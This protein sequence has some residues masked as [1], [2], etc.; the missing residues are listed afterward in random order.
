M[1]DS[2]K[3]NGW[4]AEFSPLLGKITTLLQ[5]DIILFY[6]KNLDEGFDASELAS[7]LKYEDIPQVEEDLE[8]LEEA[9]L[10]SSE[11]RGVI[12]SKHFRYTPEASLK[13]ALAGIFGEE[14]D[15]N[16]QKA[17]RVFLEKES[18]RRA[19]KRKIVLLAGAILIAL[20]LGL[21]V[22]YLVENIRDAARE[23]VLEDLSEFTGL[24]ETWYSS[25]QIKSR[26]EYSQGRRE[27][28]F[29]AWFPNG[30]RM[31]EG[32]YKDH[33]PDGRWIYWNERGEPLERIFYQDGRA[34][35]E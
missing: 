25:G 22:Y 17:L 13:P 34:V 1:I 2:R 20:G 21:G 3:P 27:G 29:H 24:H 28:S 19:G 11:V 16:S 8:K 14:S 9:G 10:L 23:E 6:Q 4:R 7:A 31:A 35:A 30:A 5:A 32:S 33:R 12:Q 18:R 26:I 15:G